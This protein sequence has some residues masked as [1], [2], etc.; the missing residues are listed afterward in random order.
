MSLVEN[1]SLIV[2]GLELRASETDDSPG[3]ISGQ[4]LPIGRIASD[5]QEVFVPNSAVF[6]SGGVKLLLS[7]GGEVIMMFEPIVV[8]DGYDVEAVLPSSPSGIQ[9]AELVRTGTRTALSVEFRCLEAEIVSQVR[10]VRSALIS[11]AALVPEGAYSAS[12]SR[13]PRACASVVALTWL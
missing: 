5:R 10:E 8:E 7:H 3:T 12:E 11:A 4:F 1:E 9:A 6:P 13:A 2:S